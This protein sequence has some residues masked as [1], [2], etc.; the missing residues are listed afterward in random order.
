M[1]C[2]SATFWIIWEIKAS[3][4]RRTSTR[5]AASSRKRSISSYR[6][7][8]RASG[9]GNPTRAKQTTRQPPQQTPLTRA[10]KPATSPWVTGELS[11]S[12][13]TAWP[14]WN[15]ARY[16]VFLSTA[17]CPSA[18]TRS[19]TR[20]TRTAI[21]TGG[22][23]IATQLASTWSI[24]FWSRRS[25]CSRTQASGWWQAAV[26]EQIAPE[27]SNRGWIQRKPSGTITTSSCFVDRKTRSP[28]FT[29]RQTIY[30]FL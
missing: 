22:W 23:T 5:S 20:S 24:L 29:V 9:W 28:A 27:I 26:P 30:I 19:A 11:P 13:E 25:T 8:W 14:T 12:G 15:F 4:S 18:E 7:W 6:K 16:R 3:L 21:P 17:A 1:A 2:S 10:R